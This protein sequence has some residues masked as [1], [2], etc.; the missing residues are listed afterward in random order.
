MATSVGVGSSAK[1]P[2]KVSLAQDVTFTFD[3]TTTLPATFRYGITYDTSHYGSNPI[4]DQPSCTSTAAGCFYDS[5]NVAEAPT[6]ATSGAT[7]TMFLDAAGSQV[8]GDPDY[9]PAVQFKAGN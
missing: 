8:G 6:N 9:T 2:I 7:D 1:L 3:G 4:G 5:L